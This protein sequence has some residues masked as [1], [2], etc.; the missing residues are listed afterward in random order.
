MS[1]NLDEPGCP[2]SSH[3]EKLKTNGGDLTLVDLLIEWSIIGH[4][5]WSPEN[6]V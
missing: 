5:N 2:K 4:F 1:I 6:N 3:S